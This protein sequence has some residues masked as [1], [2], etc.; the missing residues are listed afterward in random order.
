[1]EHVREIFR[2]YGTEFYYV[3]LNAPQS[4]RL[5]RGVTE[6]R[7]AH[8]PAKRDTAFSQRLLMKDDSNHRL[9]SREGE[10]T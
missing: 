9:E 5:E 10:R 6:N 3:E 7:L 4:V 1:M 8:K 2:P